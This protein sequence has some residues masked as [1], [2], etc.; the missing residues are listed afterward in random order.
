[1]QQANNACSGRCAVFSGSAA[2]LARFG[3]VAW[4]AGSRLNSRFVDPRAKC[5]SGDRRCFSEDRR[6]VGKPARQKSS[7]PRVGVATSS[8]LVTAAL[9]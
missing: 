5:V 7:A 9:R 3:F 8:G 4:M 2:Q 6:T 1:M